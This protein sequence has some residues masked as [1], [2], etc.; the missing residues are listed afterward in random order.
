MD[1]WETVTYKFLNSF[2]VDS[3][4]FEPLGKAKPPDF[5]VGGT[6]A[7]ETTRLTKIVNID[8]INIDI[9][10]FQIRFIDSLQN[11]LKKFQPIASRTTYFV[12]ITYKHPINPRQAASNVRD[13]ILALHGKEDLNGTEVRISP[14]LKISF[15]AASSENDDRFLIGAV[16]CLNSGGWIYDDVLTQT[17]EALKRKTQK[18]GHLKN[19][20][21][22]YWIAVGSGDTR[23]LSF[24]Y[25][26]DLEKHLSGIGFW[27]KIIFLNSFNPKESKVINME[28]NDLS[29]YNHSRNSSISTPSG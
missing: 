12:S 5:S 1:Y 17:V 20:F 26:V 28:N 24:K 23:N 4:I 16:S 14:F 18:L 19:D 8:G 10:D 15:A 9:N 6:V 21:K 13:A 25:L 7:V 11:Q 27:Q 2:Y 22:E 29:L 3:I